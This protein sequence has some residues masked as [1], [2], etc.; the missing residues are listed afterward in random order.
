MSGC[1]DRAPGRAEA[2][3]GTYHRTS[4]GETT[5][6]GFARAIFAELG[7]D[8]ARVLPTSTDA[9]PRLAPQPA[10]SVL[11]HEAWRGAALDP[12]P[13]RRESLMRVIPLVAPSA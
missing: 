10:N 6:F 4:A 2:P 3:F 5:W 9:F 8:P 1:R 13:S 12:L 7:L 11:R